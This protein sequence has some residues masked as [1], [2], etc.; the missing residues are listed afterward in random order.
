MRY[1]NIYF[2]YLLESP[3]WGDSNKYTKYMYYEK[4]R[5]S[6]GLYY[7]S[8]CPLRILYNSKFIKMATYLW[9]H[10]VVVGF[11]V[12]HVTSLFLALRRRDICKQCRLRS[13]RASWVQ[14]GQSLRWSHAPSTASM[15]SKEGLARILAVLSGWTG[16]YEPYRSLYKP[17]GIRILWWI[18]I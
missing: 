5:I 1:R 15:L 16:R 17:I 10:A 6:Q 7:I 14:S 4:M 18:S 2:E 3:Q 11:I 13:E 8:C 12:F 9:T